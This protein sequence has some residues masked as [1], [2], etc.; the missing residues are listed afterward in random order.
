MNITISVPAVVEEYMDKVN[1][2]IGTNYKLF[3]YYG[4]PDAENIIIAMG[5]ICDVAEEVIDY[6][7]A[8]GE[9]VGLVKVRLYRP[10]CAE[11]L[12]EAI[13]AT[14]KNIAVLDRTKEPGSIGE[15]LYLDVVAA[16]AAT[17]QKRQRSSADV[18]DSVQRILLLQA[19]L[20]YMTSLRRQSRRHN[21]TL[22]INDDVTHLSLEEKPAPNTAAEGTIGM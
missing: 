3:N 11:K 21:F 10:F 18:T 4:A 8:A 22:G 14:V 17:R 19:C 7:T 12:A 20:Q 9:K 6:L 13:P 15:P 2:K 16:L 1:A 5:S